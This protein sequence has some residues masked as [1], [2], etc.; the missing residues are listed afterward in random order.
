[1]LL[2]YQLLM[3]LT[4]LARS[5]TIAPTYSV[6]PTETALFENGHVKRWSRESLEKDLREGEQ[7]C[8]FVLVGATWD[9][10]FKRFV[11]QEYWQRLANVLSTDK[12]VIV[13]AMLYNYEN[14][15][16]VANTTSE[17]RIWHESPGSY[18]VSVFGRGGV[19]VEDSRNPVHR[20]AWWSEDLRAKIARTNQEYLQDA[21]FACS[22]EPRSVQEL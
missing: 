4:V 13:G 19:L 14:L 18:D 6:S 3:S 20:S 1:M 10:H 7:E 16:W 11:D 5:L 9:G 22:L 15:P 8:T 2:L 21:Y 12:T 17:K